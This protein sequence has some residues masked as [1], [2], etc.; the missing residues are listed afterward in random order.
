[1]VNR[2]FPFWSK[3]HFS[4]FT[5]PIAQNFFAKISLICLLITSLV[6]LSGNSAQVSAFLQKRRSSKKWLRPW[7]I[8]NEILP[9]WGY[10]MFMFCTEAIKLPYILDCNAPLFFALLKRD[11]VIPEHLFW[12]TQ[13]R[14]TYYGHNRDLIWG[15]HAWK[16]ELISSTG[17]KVIRIFTAFCH[18]LEV[19]QCWDLC[20][21]S[22]QLY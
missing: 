11:A 2:Y 10:K 3:N 15:H 13:K 19:C 18:N 8:Q 5:E 17:K 16:G 22:R 14:S 21:V 7:P 4:A 20:W 9:M 12:I 6:Q 1:M